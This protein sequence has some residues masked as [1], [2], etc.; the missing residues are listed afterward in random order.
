LE[1]GQQ[2]SEDA[3][4]PPVF[5]LDG[6]KLVDLF[7]ISSSSFFYAALPR[8]L[9]IGTLALPSNGKLSIKRLVDGLRAVVFK[10]GGLCNGGLCGDIVA[11]GTNYQGIERGGR[12]A[13]ASSMVVCRPNRLMVATCVHSEVLEKKK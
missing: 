1:L 8:T 3:S 13:R 7:Q 4:P 12:C 10:I 2:E 6:T 11:D 5:E 9:P